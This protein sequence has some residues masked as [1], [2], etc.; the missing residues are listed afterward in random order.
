MQR[1]EL[2]GWLKLLDARG[3]GY[4]GANRLIAAFGSIQAVCSAPAAA[5]K[6]HLG[7]LPDALRSL[8]GDADDAAVAKV[9]DWLGASRQ[10]HLIPF[11]DPRYPRLL[12]E[13]P[14]PPV[15]FYATGDVSLLDQPLLAMVGSRNPT[16]DGAHNA[17]AFS[18]YLCRAGLGI[19]SGMATGIDA[20]AHQGALDAGGK[21]IAVIGT[22]ID[23]VYPARHRQLAHAIAEQ[24][25]IVSEFPLG[26]PP[27]R[28]NFP[29]RNR[30]ISG[31]SL[32]VLVV[33]AA[34]KSGSLITAR[35]AGE[36]GREVFAIPGSIHAPLAK[37][38]N[39]LIRQG[40]KLV[41]SG[42]HV[43]EELGPISGVLKEM[44]AAEAPPR[45]IELSDELEAL[46]RHLGH[47]PQTMDQLIARSG[48]TAAQVSSILSQLEIRGLA[49]CQHGGTFI[50]TSTESG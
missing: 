44:P 35:M 4:A 33:E 3:V 8:S 42:R 2:C 18:R 28:H 5:L 16:S 26:A 23:R 27:S 30:L 24:G 34:A 19:V 31:L 1:E 11:T 14:D 9:E 41:E 50:R 39:R 32:G 43:I 36:Q 45:Q 47:D 15:L 22:G 38:C 12:R 29:R 13:I 25:L 21:T 10:N 6:P 46:Y 37:G 48:L 40:A 20:L 7:N 49:E 17:R